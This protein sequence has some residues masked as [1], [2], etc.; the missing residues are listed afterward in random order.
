M[1][2]Q[3]LVS[4]TVEELLLAALERG[5]GGLETGRYVITFRE[6]AIEEGVHL[7]SEL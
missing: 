7:I 4:A 1:N 5:D 2:D 3:M 6:G